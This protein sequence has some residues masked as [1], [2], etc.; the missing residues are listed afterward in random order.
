M[1]NTVSKII[2]CVML[3]CSYNKNRMCRAI[4]VTVGGPHP[5]CDTFLKSPQKGGANKVGVV[6]ACK[7]TECSYNKSLECCASGIH[8]GIHQ[9]HADC[10]TYLQQSVYSGFI[11]TGAYAA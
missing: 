10:S 2:D 5:M 11:R 3:D 8:M 4:A 7:N 9:N 1:V 6:G